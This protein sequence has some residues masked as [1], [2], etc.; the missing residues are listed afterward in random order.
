M[1]LS[2]ALL[3]FPR[4]TSV[5]PHEYSERGALGDLFLMARVGWGGG[6][7]MC[8]CHLGVT[9]RGKETNPISRTYEVLFLIYFLP[10]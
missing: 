3:N 7:M 5:S 4:K 1:Q 10:F 8:W 2:V 6:G 9:K